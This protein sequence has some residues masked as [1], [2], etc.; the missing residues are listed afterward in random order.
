[1]MILTTDST[2]KKSVTGSLPASASQNTPE[3]TDGQAAR[4]TRIGYN[5]RYLTAC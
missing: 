4:G 5:I 2:L 1:M 3:N